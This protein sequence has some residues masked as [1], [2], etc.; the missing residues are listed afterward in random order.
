MNCVQTATLLINVRLSRT[1]TEVP[2]TRA[3]DDG[4]FCRCFA[5]DRSSWATRSCGGECTCSGQPPKSPRGASSLAPRPSSPS[6][7]SVRPVPSPHPRSPTSRPCSLSLPLS[8]SRDDTDCQSPPP[9]RPQ[10]SA[11]STPAARA[12]SAWGSCRTKRA[13][14]SSS[15]AP[16]MARRLRRCRS[17]RTRSRRASRRI[18]RGESRP[19]SVFCLGVGVCVAWGPSPKPVRTGNRQEM[20]GLGYLGRNSISAKLIVFVFVGRTSGP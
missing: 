15:R 2:V 6:P 10:H 4:P 3:A 14:G 17:L 5:E 19:Y 8:C 1:S 12:T 13:S 11:Q 18:G 7:R 20:A 9:I 16:C